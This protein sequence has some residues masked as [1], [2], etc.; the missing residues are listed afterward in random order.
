MKPRVAISIGM[1]LMLTPVGWEIS[2]NWIST[3]P[4]AVAASGKVFNGQIIQ[5]QGNVQ[6]KRSPN[7]VIRPKTGTRVYPGDEL[8]AANGAQ[9]LVQ[10]ADLT[11]WLVRAGESQLNSCPNATEQAQ[12]SPGLYKCPHRGD[13][14]AWTDGI[15]YII[16]P[17][18]TA[19]L[20]NKP[21]LRWHPVP[22]AKSYT[23]SVEGENVNWKTQVTNSQVV[24]S[25]EQPLKPGGRYMLTV[26]A[27]TGASSV[28]EPVQPGGINFGLLDEAQA[29]QVQAQAKQ[30]TQQ[31]WTDQAKALALANLYTE[32]GLI[33]DAI[34][35]LE[36]LV[37]NGV[38]TAPIY[39]TLG[40]LY[41][42][43]LVLVPQAN[44]YYS[45][46]IEL[47]DAEDV[48]ERTAAQDGLEQVQQA[49]A[50]QDRSNPHNQNKDVLPERLYDQKK[51]L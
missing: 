51:G 47:V 38:Q 9:A 31:T 18:R 11:T 26:V 7:R 23:V 45:K 46:A 15:P 28:D 24:Y 50:N 3:I 27:D 4:V 12:C 44:V 22:G 25:G 10:C 39:R 43:Y 29:Q 14:L 5:I 21:T 20:N 19:L 34:A 42:K 32:N 48:E 6:L 36:K 1:S 30:I 13:D 2:S 35:T 41:L 17:R 8:L 16:S 33:A 40:D 37:N 49:L